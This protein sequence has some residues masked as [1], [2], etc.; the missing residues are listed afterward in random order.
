MKIFQSVY[1]NQHWHSPLPQ[2]A[3]A[4]WLLAFGDHN[5]MSSDDFRQELK[6]AFPQAQIIGCTTSGEI[7]GNLI[8]DNSICLTAVEFSSSNIHVVSDA[9]G[10]YKNSDDLISHL[11]CQLPDVGLKHV[12]IISDGQ[13][14]NGS[15]LVD[16]LQRHL[17]EG[18]TATGGLAGD[19]DKF[20][21]TTVWHNDRVENGLVVVAGFYGDNLNIGHGNLGGWHPFGPKRIITKSQANVLLEIDNQPALDLYKNFLGEF[22]DG[23]PASA[24]LYPLALQLEGESEQL[25]RTILSIDEESKSMVFA[26]NMPE[27]SSC[28]LMQSNYEDLIDGAQMAAKQALSSNEQ[29]HPELAILIS[30]VG[31]R[32]VLGQRVE[33]E[34]EIIE[35]TFPSNCAFSGFYS[36][37][38]ISPIKAIGRCGLHNQTMTIT[39]FSEN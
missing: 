23:L 36:Y 3:K 4:Q 15:E 17:P 1:Q 16:G 24:L 20:E 30:C 9:I 27:G 33:E 26:G 13:L 34:L 22:A 35:D 39:L 5:A 29:I 12:F 11:L 25:V 2:S 37:G 18:V 10:N 21:Q 32:L 19:G 6:S 8:F 31:R 7:Q 28:Q 38:E 14:V